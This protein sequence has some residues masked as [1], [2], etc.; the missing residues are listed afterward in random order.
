MGIRLSRHLTDFGQG[1]LLGISAIL[2][3]E[4]IRRPLWAHYMR[5][6][7]AQPSDLD[8]KAETPELELPAPK[9]ELPPVAL[10]SSES[11]ERLLSLYRNWER[12]FSHATVF[13]RQ[14]VCHYEANAPRSM[15]LLTIVLRDYVLTGVM[16]RL[17]QI[18]TKFN[19]FTPQHSTQEELE[20]LK[21]GVHAITKYCHNHLIHW[22]NTAG[23]VIRGQKNLF[24]SDA[25]TM[26]YRDYEAAV[27][28][29]KSHEF[30]SEIKHLAKKLE[31]ME[32]KLRKPEDPP[33]TASG[34]APPP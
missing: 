3:A 30:H 18:S 24:S 22:I 12:A 33:T 8:I 27:T 15:E 26:L 6:R 9:P 1:I 2:L 25:Y 20:E 13:F 7:K 5:N 11:C 4:G 10:A 23:P 21:A 31:T 19:A 34:Q 29:S 17:E 28:A 32:P 14:E 16:E